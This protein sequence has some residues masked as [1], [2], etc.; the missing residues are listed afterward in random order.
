MSAVR[1][2]R[3]DDGYDARGQGN[4]QGLQY[5]EIDFLH[6][7]FGRPAIGQFDQS[8]DGS[9]QNQNNRK[10]DDENKWDQQLPLSDM[11]E[12]GIE[13]GVAMRFIAFIDVPEEVQP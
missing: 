10:G 1:H 12:L 11:G 5:H 8:V 3:R 6:R 4:H 2:T 7:Q 9:D 13:F